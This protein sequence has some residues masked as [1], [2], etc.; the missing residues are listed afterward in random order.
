M[1]DL[2]LLNIV[3]DLLEFAHGL[4]SDHIT[5][6]RHDLEEQMDILDR[7][8]HLGLADVSKLVATD[9]PYPLFHGDLALVIGPSGLM[10]ELCFSELFH[11]WV[12][13][14]Q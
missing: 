7:D 13:C 6:E 8:A 10:D 11:P 3:M 2:A 4:S 1:H 12:L 9:A 14:N 5:R